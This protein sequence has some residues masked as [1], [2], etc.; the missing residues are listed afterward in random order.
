LFYKTGHIDHNTFSGGYEIIYQYYHHIFGRASPKADKRRAYQGVPMS[1]Y[2][3]QQ[4]KY[5]Q[6][7][8]REFCEKPFFTP[9]QFRVF[10]ESGICRI[11]LSFDDKICCPNGMSY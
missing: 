10:I 3:F 7:L 4:S 11:S 6:L 8:Q 1:M 2:H 5:N 9:A